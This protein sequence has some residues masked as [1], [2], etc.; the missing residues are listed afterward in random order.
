[1]VGGVAGLFN[2]GLL[3]VIG[4]VLSVYSV[5]VEHKVEHKGDDNPDGEEFRA[6]CD[7][8]LI[9]ASCSAVFSLPEGKM[10]SFFGIVPPGHVLDVPNGL[11]G[12]LF[13]TYIFLR[14]FIGE[15]PAMFTP[16]VNM[17]ISTLAIA[18]SAFLGRKLYMLREFCVVCVSTHV[19]NSTLW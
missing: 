11:L 9:G 4:V 2:N 6:L 18:S 14:Y 15:R 7:I 8:E 17:T 3:S 1:M 19:I 12:M 5:Y 16:S 10:L 13:Y